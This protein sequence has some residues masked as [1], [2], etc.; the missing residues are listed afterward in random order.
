MYRQYEN[1]HELKDRLK[2]LE[3]EYTKAVGENADEDRLI[4]LSEDIAELKDRINCAW[5]D[6]EYDSES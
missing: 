4:A 3:K 2:E 5:Q 6:D 1:P